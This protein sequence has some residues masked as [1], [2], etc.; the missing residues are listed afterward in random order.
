MEQTEWGK[1]I[2]AHTLP[3]ITRQMRFIPLPAE[4]TA[5]YTETPGYE[6]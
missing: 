2:A 6:S 5:S 3:I 4:F 1:T